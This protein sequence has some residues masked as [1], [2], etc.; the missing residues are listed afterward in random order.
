VTR[1]VEG[2]DREAT[3]SSE[4]TDDGA[5]MHM[6]C[7]KRRECWLVIEPHFDDACFSYAGTIIAQRAMFDSLRILTVFSRSAYTVTGYMLSATGGSATEVV[8]KLRKA[9]GMQFATAIQAKSEACDLPEALLRGYAAP[10]AVPRV[11]DWFECRIRI[12][13]VVRTMLVQQR[14]DRLSFPLGAAIHLDHKVVG[15]AL[16]DLVVEASAL[17]RH[18]E[19][20]AYRENPYAFDDPLGVSE[21]VSYIERQWPVTL[22]PIYQDTTNVIEQKLRL[23]SLFASQLSDEVSKIE[24]VDRQET[25]GR[26]TYRELGWRVTGR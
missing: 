6:L 18:I 21:R 1:L 25:S 8:S 17:L 10:S 15:D 3:P 16:F 23:M 9:E 12:Q 20:F 5:G 26:T 7:R 14:V 19:V 24:A 4:V 22:T 13:E 2:I 11:D